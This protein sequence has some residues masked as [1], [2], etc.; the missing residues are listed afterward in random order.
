[1]TTFWANQILNENKKVIFEWVMNDSGDSIYLEGSLE[2]GF[3]QEYWRKPHHLRQWL[4]D[5]NPKWDW[6]QTEV[7][8]SS[9]F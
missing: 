1:M 5:N 2:E 4:K 8:V 7:E 6:K 9:L 3:P